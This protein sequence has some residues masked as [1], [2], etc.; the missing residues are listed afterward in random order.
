M[1]ASKHNAENERLKRKYFAYLKEAKRYSES[2]LDEVAKALTASSLIP[3]SEASV[4]SI[5][6]SL[7][8]SSAISLRSAMREWISRS[9]RP[10]SRERSPS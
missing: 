7:S 5:F 3:N 4:N 1:S 10:R 9:A 8:P 6:S 2:S